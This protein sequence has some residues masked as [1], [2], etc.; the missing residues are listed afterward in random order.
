M[1]KIKF[2]AFNGEVMNYSI[3][4]GKFGSFWINSGL[5]NNGLDDSDSLS[6]TKFNTK[7]SETTIIMQFSGLEDKTGK[8]VY[9]K[10][11]ILDFND[12]GEEFID[13]V[14]YSEEMQ[15]FELKKSKQPLNILTEDFKIIGNIYEN[16]DL[17][18]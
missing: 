8:E 7:C 17:L 2:R 4:S 16:S 5:N 3:I 12:M 9:E 14:I 15:W 1:R 10:D 13:I 11:I 6:L 18:H